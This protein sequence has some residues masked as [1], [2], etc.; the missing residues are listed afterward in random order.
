M[1]SGF[2]QNGRMTLSACS[3]SEGVLRAKWPHIRPTRRQR[4]CRVGR[5]PHSSVL[6]CCAA[7]LHGPT[8]R[9]RRH[10]A[11]TDIS[12]AETKPRTV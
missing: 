5:N 1:T 9:D 10:E 4:V 3:T 8:Q 11:L 6:G 12:L 2:T 7:K